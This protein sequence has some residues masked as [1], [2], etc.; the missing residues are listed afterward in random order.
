MTAPPGRGGERIPSVLKKAVVLGV[1][2]EFGAALL[3]KAG[4]AKNSRASVMKLDPTPVLIREI[5]GELKSL[6]TKGVSVASPSSER[7]E[8]VEGCVPETVSFASPRVAFVKVNM[9]TVCP[10]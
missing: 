7:T 2:A 5:E 4:E 10:R 9:G 1:I 6:L 3:V 8:G